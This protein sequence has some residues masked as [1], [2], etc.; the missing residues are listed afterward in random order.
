MPDHVPCSNT[1]GKAGATWPL[2]WTQKAHAMQ[3]LHSSNVKKQY[4]QLKTMCAKM[5]KYYTVIN[6]Q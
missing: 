3:I 4:K 6:N 5:R 1:N 2:A